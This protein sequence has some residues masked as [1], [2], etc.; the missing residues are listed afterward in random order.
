MEET[1]EE[2]A[3]HTPY[4]ICNDWMYQSFAEICEEN[5]NVTMMTNSVANNGNPFGASDYQKIKEGF[6]R[7]ALKSRSMKAGCLTMERVLP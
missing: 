1:D 2:V 7:Q 4:V 3:I 5:P 6:W